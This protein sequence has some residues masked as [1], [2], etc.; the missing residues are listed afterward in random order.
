MLTH[1]SHVYDLAFSASAEAV[2]LAM[3]IA[4]HIAANDDRR[5]ILHGEA[6]ILEDSIN[7]LLSVLPQSIGEGSHH[8]DMLMRHMW[9]IH[10]WLEQDQPIKCLADPKDMVRSDIPGVLKLYDEWYQQQSLGDSELSS[11]IDPFIK[12]GQLNAGLREAWAVFKTR[13]VK[14]FGLADTLDGHNLAEALLGPEGAA[15]AVIEEGERQGYLNLLKGL[16]TLYRNPVT[17]N[18]IHC[19]PQEVDSVLVMLDAILARVSEVGSQSG[20]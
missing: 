13:T 8:S 11:R 7:Q 4:V 14:A 3:M 10:Y 5:P 17:H 12:A 20:K 16:Y 9:L 6:R 2:D 15:A 18:D 1:R 19:S